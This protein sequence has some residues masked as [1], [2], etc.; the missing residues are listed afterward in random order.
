[1]EAVLLLEV[2]KR[3][4]AGRERKYGEDRGGELELELLEHIGRLRRYETI[5]R[6]AQSTF[7]TGPGIRKA[8]SRVPDFSITSK[9]RVRNAPDFGRNTLCGSVYPSSHTGS[10]LSQGWIW[11]SSY[12]RSSA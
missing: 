7:S 10:A 2:D 5:T 8:V 12:L 6:P 1:A 3:R 11:A 4:H 9:R